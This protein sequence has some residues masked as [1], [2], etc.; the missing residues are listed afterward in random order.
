ME[1][2]SLLNLESIKNDLG[3]LLKGIGVSLKD[4]FE[5]GSKE[6]SHKRDANDILTKYDTETNNKILQYL[7]KK[8]PDISIV[9]EEADEISKT[10]EYSFVID[11][12]DGTRNFVRS[13]PIFYIGIGLV[14]DNET[15]LCVTYN[16][17][18]QELFWAIKGRGA[19]LNNKKLEVSKR[20]IE[21]ADIQIRTVP[22]KKKEKEIVFKII[23][24]AF[25]VKNEMC[26]HHEIAGVA[27]DRYDGFISK[28][29]NVWDYCQ[30]L[31]VEEAGGRVTDWNGD[32]FDLSKDN[33]VASNGVIHDDLLKIVK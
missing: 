32:K 19:Y 14:K 13:I 4:G 6:F 16:P 23:E 27:C 29:S 26:C 33:I 12:I 15:L 9:S 28:N 17:I 31:L 7:E 21:L 11:P 30:Y 20:T 22:D 3:V 25:Q 18:S 8:Y 1:E 24:T 5:N 2:Y 10:S